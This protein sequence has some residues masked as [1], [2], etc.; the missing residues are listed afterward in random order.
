[1]L[2]IGFNVVS[3]LRHDA[4]LY[5]LWDGEPT[6]NPGRPRVKGGKIDFKNIDKSK[7][8]ILDTDKCM[9]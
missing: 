1:M 9:P 8:A 3:R 6:D 4:A 5:Y 7:I 2:G